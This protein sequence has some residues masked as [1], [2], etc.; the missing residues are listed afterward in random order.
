M[1]G[2]DDADESDEAGCNLET[3]AEKILSKVWRQEL[4]YDKFS[5]LISRIVVSVA[6]V[7]EETGAV[8]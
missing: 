1:I 7:R 6:N 2:E 3:R 5:A 4:G 8:C